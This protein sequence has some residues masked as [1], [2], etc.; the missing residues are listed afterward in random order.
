M[1]RFVDIV[2]QALGRK[3]VNEY[4]VLPRRTETK[5]LDYTISMATSA[6]FFD[7]SDNNR[8]IDLRNI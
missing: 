7:V 5:N 2:S 3:S 6:V 4:P 1:N 8:D